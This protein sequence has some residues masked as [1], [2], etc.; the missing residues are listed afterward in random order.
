MLGADGGGDILHAQAEPFEA[1]R[2][3]FVR[4]A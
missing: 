1:G 2:I 4:F 3:D